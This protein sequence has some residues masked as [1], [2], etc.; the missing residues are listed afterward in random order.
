MLNVKHHARQ[1][2]G[3][4]K[5][6]ID[7]LPKRTKVVYVRLTDGQYRQLREAAGRHVACMNAFCLAAL[8]KAVLETMQEARQDAETN[9]A[10]A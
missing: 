1:G 10:Q 9:S 2:A 3:L 7:A 4:K 5:S 8:E 6:E